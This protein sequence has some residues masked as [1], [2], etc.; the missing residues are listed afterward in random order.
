MKLKYCFGI[1]HRTLPILIK[2]STYVKN[3]YLQTSFSS[4][5]HF[6]QQDCFP[7]PGSDWRSLRVLE[8][9]L[10]AHG[11]D[12]CGVER[13]LRDF[14]RVALSMWFGGRVIQKGHDLP[15][16]SHQHMPQ[17]PGDLEPWV[18]RPLLVMLALRGLSIH[19]GAGH[20]PF[21]TRELWGT[22]FEEDGSGCSFLSSHAPHQL[23]SAAHL[24]QKPPA[25][26]S[27]QYHSTPC[28]PL[29]SLLKEQVSL[30][31][32]YYPATYLC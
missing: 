1:C 15:R 16:V 18:P 8:V 27:E 12:P 22:Y 4:L 2:C 32:S 3:M 11:L 31:H 26:V 9:L 24:Q 6:P 17:E 5:T 20:F 19:Q 25:L 14:P 28:D 7:G 30:L 13:S 29:C 23:L 10:G 21:V